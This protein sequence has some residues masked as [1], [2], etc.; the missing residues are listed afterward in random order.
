M[1]LTQKKLLLAY[2]NQKMVRD[3][4]AE[5]FWEDVALITLDEPFDISQRI[6]NPVC[7]PHKLSHID[8]RW[9]YHDFI[10]SGWGD[11]DN[12]TIESEI[13]KSAIV[14]KVGNIKC[15]LDRFPK[16]VHEKDL[17][18]S[19]IGFCLIG[20]HRK[21]S[22]CVGDSGGPAIWEDPKY[23]NRAYLMGIASET[24]HEKCGN[25]PIA[26][27]TFVAVPGDVMTW[28]LSKGG[29]DVDEC[30]VKDSFQYSYNEVQ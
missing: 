5:F 16:E 10:I 28:V 7:L 24:H 6:V 8:E 18:Q 4:T 21:E 26:P 9:N 2:Q 13:L 15:F 12:S 14:Q 17:D 3:K 29:K 19:R 25:P 22:L 23:N 30:L 20:K 11:H 27:S 1:P